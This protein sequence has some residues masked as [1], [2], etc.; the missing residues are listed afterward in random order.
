M[1]TLKHLLLSDVLVGD[2]LRR[3]YGDLPELMA[4]LIQHGQIQPIT[5]DHDNR[6]IAG[7]RRYYSHVELVNQGYSAFSSIWS[8]VKDVPSETDR[9]EQELEENF[10]RKDMTWTEYV[11]GVKEIHSLKRQAA[12]VEGRDWSQETTAISIGVTRGRVSQILP[13]AD[14]LLRDPESSLWKCPNISDALRELI[15][16]AQR[17]AET[18]LLVMSRQTSGLTLAGAVPSLLGVPTSKGAEAPTLTS[19]A[20]FLNN[21]GSANVV[22]NPPGSVPSPLE[23]P[24]PSIHIELATQ[25]FVGSCLDWMSLNPSSVDHI[26]CDPPYAIDMANLQQSN[27]NMMDVRGTSAEHVVDENLD[28]LYKFVPAAFKVIR[29]KGFLVMFCD[30][31]N[32]RLLVNLGESAGFAVQRWPV[33]WTKLSAKNECAGF[34]FTKAAEC[35]VIMRKPG[36]VLCEHQPL[37]WRTISSS[38]VD[39]DFDHPFAKPRELWQWIARAVSSEGQRIYDPFAGCGSGP[40]AFATIGRKWLASELSAE[41]VAPFLTNMSRLYKTTHPTATITFNPSTPAIV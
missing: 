6:L 22:P 21:V 11:L 41:W 25:F 19:L 13:L 3:D 30:F 33:I 2:R 31:M 17:R 27:S 40:C 9:R 1:S 18:R 4:S 32:F 34:N 39:K 37:N 29:D 36:S 15:I 35:A 14:E 23:P 5:V 16:L 24:A 26:I 28:L 12:M 20:D 8:F 10:R 38:P 7:G